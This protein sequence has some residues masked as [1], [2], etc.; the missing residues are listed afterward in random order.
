VGKPEGGH[1]EDPHIDG[2]V[3]LQWFFKKRDASMNWINL[4]Q[5]RDR[6]RAVMN[7]AMNLRGP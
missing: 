5:D 6:W 2:S 7:A 4:A 1:S 3:V